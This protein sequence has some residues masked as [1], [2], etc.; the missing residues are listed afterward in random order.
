VRRAFLDTFAASLRALGEASERGIEPA[1]IRRVELLCVRTF[2]GRG[3]DMAEAAQALDD[4]EMRSVWR[5][6]PV[7]AATIDMA[8]GDE[9][10]LARMSYQLAESELVVP[11]PEGFPANPQLLDR[12]PEQLRMLADMLDAYPGP[13]L[14]RST[15]EAG[16]FEF[17]IAENETANGHAGVASTWFGRFFVGLTGELLLLP[18]FG[19]ALQQRLP[20]PG[21]LPWAGFPAVTL[22]A[23]IHVRGNTTKRR[24]AILALDEALCFAPTLV[25]HDLIAAGLLVEQYKKGPTC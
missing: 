7:I 14:R 21:V 4:D 10:A 22:A 13:M 2:D 1:A 6:A 25:E 16:C 9:G 11:V 19:D 8:A 20:P 23:A 17:L 15:L 18:P 24:M 12:A 3:A 5:A